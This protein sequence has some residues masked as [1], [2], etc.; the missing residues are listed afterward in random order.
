MIRE[1]CAVAVAWV[2]I[3]S[4][5]PQAIQSPILADLERRVADGDASAVANFWTLVD[6]RHSPLVETIP[7]DAG[8]VFATFLWK[9][10]DSVKDVVLMAQP[11]GIATFRDPRSHLVHLA[12][13][14][15]WY[16][17]HKLPRDA[18][19]S[20]MFS[21]D[22]PREHDGGSL[23]PTLH[24]D[25]YNP[26]QYRILTGPLRSI[27]RMPGVAPNPWLAAG[28]TTSR[29]VTEH[30]ISS[31]L[32]NGDRQV[33]A[34]QTPGA[35]REPQLLIL[36][37]GQTYAQSVPTPRILDNLYAAGKI[38]PTIALF[39]KDGPG[40]AWKTD[41]YFSD[42]FVDFVATELIPWAEREYQVT[43]APGRTTIG[44]DSIAGLTAA[45][46]AFRKPGVFGHVIA[47][48]ASFWLN[49]RDRDEG[50]PE[51]LS[52][53][54]LTT[55]ASNVSFAIDVG[56]MEFVA[57]EADRIFA[58]FVPGSTSLLASNR[59]LRDILRLKGYPVRY[60]ETYGDHEPLRWQRT[61]P[62]ALMFTLGGK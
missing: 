36:L 24:N 42:A 26:L 57:N 56:Q 23:M 40:D 41:M 62:D 20:Y 16:R 61:L 25:P 29:S 8:H 22:P 6:Q 53:Q 3:S 5:P 45:F 55:P 12:G 54:F 4:A 37:D 52:R 46:A 35:M 39:V 50:E 38:G 21:V 32:L 47:Q 11:D 2:L 59:H 15:V 34:Y 19:F 7:G 31:A 27:A 30:R 14:D 28:T 44:G 60:V 33:W 51:W 48:S 49:N 13:T 1:W 18:E 17:T 10:A 43:A 58:P 9:G